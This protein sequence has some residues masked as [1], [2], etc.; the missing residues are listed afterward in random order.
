MFELLHI[1]SFVNSYTCVPYNMTLTIALQTIKMY[2]ENMNN[3]QSVKVKYP[4]SSN[5]DTITRV[6]NFSVFA[7]I[8]VYMYGLFTYTVYTLTS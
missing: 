8:L 5:L 4:I 3:Y 1:S 2:R 7:D 6:W